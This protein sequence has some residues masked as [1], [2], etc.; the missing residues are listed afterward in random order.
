M[1]V[2]RFVARVKRGSWPLDWTK[3]PTADLVIW[4]AVGS[5]WIARCGAGLDFERFFVR[6]EGYNTNWKTLLLLASHL[7]PTKSLARAYVWAMMDQWG[8]ELVVTWSDNSNFHRYAEDFPEVRFVAV[9]SGW[10]FPITLGDEPP[11]PRNSQY[12]SELLCFG[13]NDIDSYAKLGI[14]FTSIRA[15]GSLKNS[16]YLDST[17]KLSDTDSEGAR[18]EF[19]L[20][21]ISQFRNGF[22]VGSSVIWLEFDQCIDLVRKLM[23]RRPHLRIA[24]AMASS[25]RAQPDEHASEVKYFH[26]R[27]GDSVSLYPRDAEEFTVYSLTDRAVLSVS[28]SS[29]AGIEALSRRRR[30][31][32]TGSQLLSNFEGVPYPSW[33]AVGTEDEVLARMEALVSADADEEFWNDYSVAAADYL[34]PNAFVISAANELREILASPREE[35]PS[36]G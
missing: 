15:I 22:T 36:L 7:R 35:A 4:D 20:C 23:E 10:R 16:L 2:R 12:R 33:L 17:E 11:L 9:Q 27:F 19:D 21:F 5:E 32:I 8:P 25:A 28:S 34:V 29:T 1:R 13:Q 24:V 3:V 18:P 6:G 14:E 31:L 26:A 30:T